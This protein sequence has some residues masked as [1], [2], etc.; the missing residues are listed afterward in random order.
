MKNILGFR[1]RFIGRRVCMWQNL[2]NVFITANPA[3]N[4]NFS[5][6]GVCL[7]K[8]II[9]RSTQGVQWNF[10]FAIPFSSAN[11]STAKSTCTA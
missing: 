3:F 11:F 6:N 5:V 7:R 1:K 2:Y 10:T 9:N 4:T 8:P